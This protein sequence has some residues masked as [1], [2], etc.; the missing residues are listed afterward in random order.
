MN[1][2]RAER[3]ALLVTAVTLAAIAGWFLHSRPAAHG[4][5]VSGAGL[6]QAPPSSSPRVFTPDAPLD[7]NSAGLDD[8]IGLPGIGE[9]RAQAI[10]DYRAQHGGFTRPQELME[11]SGIGPATYQGLESYITV[12]S[13]QGGADAR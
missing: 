2:S 10:L 13:P 7:L 3:A 12:T 5:T 6:E 11:V 9:T 1:F 8:L 4:Y